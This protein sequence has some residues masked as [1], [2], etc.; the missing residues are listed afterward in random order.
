MRKFTERACDICG[1]SFVPSSSVGKQ[2][3][4][5]CLITAHSKPMANG[6][7]EWQRS[8]DPA[9]YGQLKA[10][11]KVTKAHRAAYESA[12]GALPSN[13]HV[14]HSCDNRKCVNLDHLWVGTVQDN[15][16]DM[17]SKTRFNTSLSPADVYEIRLQYGARK[18][19]QKALAKAYGVGKGAISHI[20]RYS[21]WRH[22]PEIEGAAP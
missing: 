11:G 5:A 6:C 13:A 21:T 12:N 8:T 10:N 22:L 19:T 16:A 15:M 14:C 18:M 9:G 7:I 1:N 2:C 20:C 4:V 17:V 3:S